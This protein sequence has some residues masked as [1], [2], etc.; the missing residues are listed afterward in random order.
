[1]P[2]AQENFDKNYV[3]NPEWKDGSVVE[4]TKHELERQTA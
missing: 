1:V 2:K 3:N 4:K